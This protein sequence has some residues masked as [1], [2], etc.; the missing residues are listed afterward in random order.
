[1]NG[2]SNI[3][4]YSSVRCPRTHLDL[5]IR[6]EG[7]SGFTVNLLETL[8]AI[9]AYPLLPKPAR[10]QPVV[11]GDRL[12]EQ[13]AAPPLTHHRRKLTEQRGSPEPSPTPP[14]AA[15]QL[16][17]VTARSPAAGLLLAV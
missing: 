9:R 17:E 15:A 4:A 6:F 3:Y 16:P 11:A 8:N 10:T 5:S 7:R 1:M 13:R 12:S 2:I 14:A